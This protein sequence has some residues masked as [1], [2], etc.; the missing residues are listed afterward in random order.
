MNNYL[1]PT[2]I[3]IAAIIIGLGLGHLAKEIRI[4]QMCYDPKMTVNIAEVV[5]KEFNNSKFLKLCSKYTF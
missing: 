3:I 5:D 4:A 2:S 1:L